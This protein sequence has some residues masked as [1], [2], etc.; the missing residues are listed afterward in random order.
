MYKGDNSVLH[1]YNHII[2]P[3][4]KANV[5]RLPVSNYPDKSGSWIDNARLVKS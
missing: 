4:T 1:V 3:S 5:L 2:G